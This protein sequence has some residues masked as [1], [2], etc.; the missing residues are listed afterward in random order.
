VLPATAGSDSDWAGAQG[1]P[2]VLDKAALTADL[3]TVFTD[4]QVSCQ[5]PLTHC[6][7][8]NALALID[9]LAAGYA[10]ALCLAGSQLRQRR[11]YRTRAAH[12]VAAGL[13]ETRRPRVSCHL[14]RE[15]CRAYTHRPQCFHCRLA[16]D[17]FALYLKITDPRSADRT[18]RVQAKA[19]GLRGKAR[20]TATK[21]VLRTAL[22]PPLFTVAM[23]SYAEVSDVFHVNSR[24]VC[25]VSLIGVWRESLTDGGPGRHAG[26]TE[27]RAT[28]ER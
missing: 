13:P 18:Q 23:Q 6:S 27:P 11:R 21:T 14:A 24:L 10:R 8:L 7:V 5:S 19:V 16:L 12:C 3:I 9:K 25:L 20:F 15:L 4:L 17:L 26:F 1:V 2:D 22:S 28:H